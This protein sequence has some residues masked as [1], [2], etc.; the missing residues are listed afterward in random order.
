MPEEIN[1][2]LT[3]HVASVLFTT[4]ESGNANLLREG[5]EA[6]RIHFV[7]NSMIDSL[8]SHIDKAL[9]ERPWQRFGLE[10]GRYGLIT[11]HR[12][13]N[14]DDRSRFS[15]IAAAMKGISQ[16]IPLLFP[17]IHGPVSVS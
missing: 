3:D 10:P 8:R 15:E 6:E 12:P 14:V 7:G 9:A 4:E 13:S 1:R 16:E 11:L 17:C 5:I 2:V